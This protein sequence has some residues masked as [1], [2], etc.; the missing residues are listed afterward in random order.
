MNISLMAYKVK[1]VLSVYALVVCL[2]IPQVVTL[3]KELVAAFR[4]LPVTVKP[5]S[6]SQS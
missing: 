6:A 5:R 1:S 2:E 4:E 3:F